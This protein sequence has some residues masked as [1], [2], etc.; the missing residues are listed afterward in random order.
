MTK[1]GA[2]KAKFRS[3]SPIVLDSRTVADR[4]GHGLSLAGNEDWKGS[5]EWAKAHV[6][7]EGLLMN[8]PHSIDVV[9]RALG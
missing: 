3:G 7:N 1:C 8:E 2:D 6:R 9:A 5:P 4:F